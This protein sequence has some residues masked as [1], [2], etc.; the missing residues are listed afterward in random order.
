MKKCRILLSDEAAEINLENNETESGE[1][2]TEIE[3]MSESQF[4]MQAN[5]LFDEIKSHL[6]L[7]IILGSQE[8]RQPLR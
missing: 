8:I 6:S 4:A 2:E 1:E 3:Q 5:A 7:L